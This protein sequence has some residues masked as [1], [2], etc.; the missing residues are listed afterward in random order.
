VPE[1]ISFPMGNGDEKFLG[2]IGSCV[3]KN[4][5]FDEEPDFDEAE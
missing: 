2:W 1:V 4:A 5:D 3:D